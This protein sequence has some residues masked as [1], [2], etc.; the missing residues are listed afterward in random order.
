MS[1]GNIVVLV[2]GNGSNLQA[3]IDAATTGEGLGNG[4]IAAV[5]SSQADAFALERARQADITT[6]VVEHKQHTDRRQYDQALKHA[7][8][9]YQPDLIVLAGF[10]RI[11][12]PEFVMHYMGR[13]LNI[14]PSLLPKYPGLN[15]H[16]QVLDAGDDTHG[17]S[18]H[19]VTETLDGGPVIAQ[20]SLPVEHDDD[21]EQL[22]QRVHKLEHLLYPIVVRW[23]ML[24]RLQME[25]NQALFDG[26]EL[27]PSG[28]MLPDSH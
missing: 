8:D 27:P 26:I 1:T 17:C 15:T 25:G 5:I 21:P 11:L 7:I 18:V 6:Q 23:F 28:V 20:A 22:K 14:H 13:L 12:T 2:S 19:F 9:E 10:M 3:L 24:G 4:R 16:Q